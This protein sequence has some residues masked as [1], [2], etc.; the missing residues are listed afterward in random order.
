MSAPVSS[1][2][3]KNGK[4]T[5]QQ[6]RG[7]LLD[8]VH[9]L[10]DVRADEPREAVALGDRRGHEEECVALLHLRERLH[11]LELL[12]REELRDRALELALAGPRDVAEALAAVLLHVVLALVEPRAGLLHGALHEQALHEAAL[13]DGGGERLEAGLGEE[14][15]H[16]DPLERVAKVR[17]V[18]AEAHH[19]LAVG[20]ADERRA[21]DLRPGRGE[22]AKRRGDDVLHHG[23]DVVLR[24]VAHLHVELVELAGRAVGARVLVAE[25]RR[26][27]EVAVE[28]GDHQQLLV[29]LRRLRQRVELARVD[30]ARDEEVARALG[31]GGRED[32]R[33]VLAEAEV[34]H[35]AA[36]EGDH[37]RAQHDVLVERLAAQVEVAVLEAQVLAA[38]VRAVAREV[39]RGLVRGALDDELVRDELDLACVDVGVD[40]ALAAR[41]DLAGHRDDALEPE[42]RRL[43]EE[44]AARVDDDLGAAV[45]VA[46]VEEEDAAVV[47]LVEDPAGEAGGLARVLDAELVAGVGAV[48]VH[49][50]RTGSEVRRFER[51]QVRK[52]EGSRGCVAWRGRIPLSRAECNAIFA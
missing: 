25:A 35:A 9:R 21:V 48:G 33:L 29:D 16:V 17:L 4:S 11:L 47:A 30:A 3:S 5:I 50:G 15:G 32:R 36:E 12:G 49:G 41:D 14:G 39:D 26:D 34:L 37:L 51:S 44:R 27:L 19:R 18:R 38:D 8:Q 43:L 40:L 28:A 7:V 22:L 13:L 10:R 31:G 23:E 46:Q 20:D 45:V 6:K 24:R 42:V 1:S 2:V 52:L